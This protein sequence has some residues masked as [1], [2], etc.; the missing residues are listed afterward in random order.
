MGDIRSD[1]TISGAVAA[2]V[3]TFGGID[4][5]LNNASV[6]NLAGTLELAQRRYDLMQDVNVRGTFMLTRACLPDLVRSE[7]PHVLTLS[8]PLNLDPAWLG[9]HPGY[10][11][12]KYGMTL[13]TLRFAA[14]FASQGVA[15][16]CLWPRTTIATDQHGATLGPISGAGSNYKNPRDRETV[17][18]ATGRA[19][20][21]LTCKIHLVRDG[22]GRPLGLVLTGGNAADTSFFQTTLQTIDVHGA[23]PG[24]PRTRPD[25]VLADKAYR[26]KANRDYLTARG[27]KVTIP[28]RDDLKAN[29]ARRGA[30]GGRPRGFDS[31]AYGGRNVVERCVNKLKSC[32]GVATRY[33]KTARSYLGGVTLAATL[34]W[35]KSAV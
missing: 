13:A 34:I 16:N 19:R 31:D 4:V 32:R 14:E 33:D 6:L 8:P 9:A 11:L 23:G 20:G 2:A 12:A 18:H 10:M 35:L 7:N 5:C 21:G 25:R 3:D 24:R 26:A 27:I 30:V 15:A 1:D 29:R 17:D 28:E 22:K